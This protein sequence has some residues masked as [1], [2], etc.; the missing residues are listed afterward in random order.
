MANVLPS[1]LGI[2]RGSEGSGRRLRQFPQRKA[3]SDPASSLWPCGRR[4]W[5]S[6]L[7]LI[8]HGF[9]LVSWRVVRAAI[10]RVR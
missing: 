9:L 1:Q 6:R 4:P 5:G 10:R 2:H 8:K 3:P 7:V